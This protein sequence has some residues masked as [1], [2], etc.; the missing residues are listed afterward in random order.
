MPISRRSFIK[1]SVT[2]AGLGWAGCKGAF[3]ASAPKAVR[4]FH[5]SISIDA[6]KADPELPEIIKAAGVR[7]IWLACFFQGTWHHSI[8]ELNE[9]RTKLEKMGFAVHNITIPLGHPMY[10]ETTPDYMPALSGVPW[11]RGIRPDGKSVGGVSLHPPITEENVA[12]VKQIKTTNP[13]IIFLDDDFR[14]APSPDDIGG[15]FCEDHKKAFLEK[16]GYGE[17]EWAAL[18]ADVGTRTLS[19]VV[20]AWVTDTCDALTACF[21]AQQAAAAPE[22]QLGIMVMYSGSE[23]AGIRLQDYAGVPFRVGESHFSDGDYDPLKGKTNELFS[24]LFHRRYATPEL[25]FSETTAWPPDKLSAENMASKLAIT[26]ISDVRNTMFMSGNTPFPRTHWE[27]L[28]PAMKHNAALHERVAGHVPRGPFKHYWGEQSRWV[29]DSNAFS[30]FLATGVPFEVVEEP[31]P[32]GWT[33]L[34]DYDARTYPSATDGKHG[35][36]VYRAG[37]STSIEGGRAVAETLPD[38]FAL[39][40]E[41]VANLKDTPYVEDD[42]PVVCAWYPTANAVLLWNL[43]KAPA[44]VSLRYNEKR[45]E[46][47]LPALGIEIA[48]GIA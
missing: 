17:S 41:V 46:V 32:G 44:K 6:I 27:V 29:G 7:D 2:V 25:A 18:L 43:E 36:L 3:A 4:T 1:Q 37:G 23:R 10:T 47:E 26:T 35:T 40:R 33:F 38:L 39:K 8:A 24:V 15:C 34:S 28:A 42:V 14:L 5:A 16:H 21:R 30:L 9:Y 20:K 12:A 45:R 13:G 11:K 31:A 19:P 48:E 22:A